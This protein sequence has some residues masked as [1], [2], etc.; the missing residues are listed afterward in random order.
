MRFFRDWRS[1][2]GVAVS[3][4]C[5]WLAFR[6]EPVAGLARLIGGAHALWLLPTLAWQLLAVAAFIFSMRMRWHRNQHHRRG[7]C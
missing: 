5:L 4:L 3:V 2:V 6:N 1:W 7:E